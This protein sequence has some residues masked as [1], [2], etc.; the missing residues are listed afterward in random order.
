MFALHPRLAAD[1]VTL[2]DWPL[3]RVL[4]MNDSN[5]PWLIL[6]PRRAGVSEI[7]D[8][9][10]GDQPVL[11]AEIAR[12]SARLRTLTSPDRINVAAL[13]N[14]VPQLHVHVIARFTTDAAWP[15]PVWGVVANAPYAPEALERRVAELWATLD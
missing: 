15:R 10:A 6:V 4:L 13:G 11:M 1:T 2:A 12:A 5:Y 3:C 7:T 8:L 14:M 9:A